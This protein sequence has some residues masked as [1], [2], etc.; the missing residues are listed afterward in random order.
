MQKI[1]LL[2]V[3]DEWNMRNLLRIYLTKNGFGVSE[4]KN[5]H[6]A[7][8]LVDQHPFDLIILDVMMPDMDGW[9]VCA[10]IRETKQTPILMLTARTETKDKVHGLNI[11]ADDYLVKPFEPEELIARVFALLRRVNLS[12]SADLQPKNIILPEMVIDP[13]GRKI[14]VH[15]HSVEF[16]PKEFDLLHFLAVNPGRAFSRD[17]LL[18][19]IW[20]D[21][22][23]GDVRTVDTHI[24]NVRE[25]VRK[26]GL[27]YSPIQTVWGV[28]YKFEGPDERK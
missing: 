7:L 2:V 9:E 11:G 20:G 8:L 1:Q 5:G 16:T 19:R 22:Y 3:D 21:D 14:L 24:K 26:A 18:Q 15:D 27:T 12:E 17:N 25:K 10:K 28:G 6:E 4:A 23:L 13:E